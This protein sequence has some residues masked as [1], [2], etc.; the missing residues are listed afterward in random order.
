MIE[1]ACDFKLEAAHWLPSAPEGHRC[2]RLHGHSFLVTVS[3]SGEPQAD[4]GWLMDYAEI[5]AA[6]EPLH[7]QLD[8]RCLNDIEGLEN[9]TSERLCEWIWDRLDGT[10]PDLVAVTVAETSSARCT[11]RRTSAG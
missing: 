10:L 2:R 5:R 1:L 7:G 11:Y 3:V 9:P 6:W 4:T 8:H